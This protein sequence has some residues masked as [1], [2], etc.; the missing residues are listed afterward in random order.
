L[1]TSN[2]SAMA[3]NSATFIPVKVIISYINVRIPCG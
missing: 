2:F 3:L 1:V